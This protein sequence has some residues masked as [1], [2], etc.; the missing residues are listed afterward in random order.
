M[1]R[2]QVQL[3]E[4]TY[5]VLRRKAFERGIS[6]AALIRE[7]LREHLG[8][9]PARRRRVEDFTFIGSGRSDDGSLAPVSERHDEALGEAL[10]EELSQ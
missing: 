1:K 3:D 4:A 8:T 6:L 5:Q 2:T 7:V 10:A 9:G